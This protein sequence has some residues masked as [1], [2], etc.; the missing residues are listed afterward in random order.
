MTKGAFVVTSVQLPPAY[1]EVLDRVAAAQTTSRAAVIRQAIA[2][3]IA[4]G[5]SQ[6]PTP[7]TEH[8][9]AA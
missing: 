6:R 5:Q 1:C 7:I 2:M 3:W 9:E 8:Q 4:A